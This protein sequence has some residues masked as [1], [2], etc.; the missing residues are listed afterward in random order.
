MEFW[1]FGVAP[2]IRSLFAD[3]EWAARRKEPKDTSPVDSSGY[4][5]GFD[6]C[7]IFN[8]KPH[9]SGVMFLR[10]LDQPE[11]TK[12]K[13]ENSKAVLL[14][15][16][17][18]EPKSFKAY[19]ELVAKDLRKYGPNGSGLQVS[20]AVKAADGSVQRGE[21]Q[22]T[23]FLLSIS[24]DSSARQKMANWPASGAYLACGWCM[25]EGY[26]REKARRGG[27]TCFDG[28]AVPA[29]QAMMGLECKVGDAELQL[30][31]SA[32]HERTRLVENGLATEQAAGCNGYSEFTRW[33][34]YVSYT[35]CGSC[36]YIR[37][38]Y[39][40]LSRASWHMHYQTMMGLT[41]QSTCIID[42]FKSCQLSDWLHFLET[43][44]LF[45]LRDDMLDGIMQDMWD[46]LR[47]A[48]LHFF[49][50]VVF[51]D[52]MLAAGSTFNDDARCLAH[53]NLFAY[54][55]LIEQHLPESLL[56]YNLQ[57]LVCRLSKQ[58]TAKGCVATCEKQKQ[59]VLLC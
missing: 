28:F 8:F 9:S 11:H 44:S 49:R 52:D 22:H 27:A 23:V 12:G 26:K 53:D 5:L 4:G 57:I 21:F 15:P 10:C 43:F 34:D 13:L 36:L 41:V 7:Q 14:L 1:Y 20:E 46:R 17:P 24:A 50:I 29:E 18:K 42:A 51:D 47:S 32:Q 40:A 55:S 56:T 54:A 58:E 39:M 16:G 25:L 30:S 45:I 37:Q 35:T 38:A 19:F 48:L 31:D 3:P 6:F 33:L 59:G 2:A